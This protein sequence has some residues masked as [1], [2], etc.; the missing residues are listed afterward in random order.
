M[1]RSPEETRADLEKIRSTLAG[2]RAGFTAAKPILELKL[3]TATAAGAAKVVEN[4]VA[5][6]TA[7]V[8]VLAELEQRTATL[9]KLIA[10]IFA[11]LE[12]MSRELAA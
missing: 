12:S 2:L 5:M 9:E 8:L 6:Q 7:M 3:G 10:E 11:G 1:P 4:L